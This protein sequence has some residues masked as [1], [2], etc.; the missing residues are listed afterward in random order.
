MFTTVIL[1][2]LGVFTLILGLRP[3]IQFL[4]SRSWVCKDD[5]KIIFKVERMLSDN[6]D[7]YYVKPTGNYEFN[8]RSYPIKRLKFGYPSIS[9]RD[10]AYAVVNDLNAQEARIYINPNRP[11]DHVVDRTFPDESSYLVVIGL[12]VTCAGI[13]SAFGYEAASR[14]VMSL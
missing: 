9:N 7:S 3:V 2:I 4:F 5:V 8:G 11:S 12:Y 6:G 1:L 14:D 13:L 10:R